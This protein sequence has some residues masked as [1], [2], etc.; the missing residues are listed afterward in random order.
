MDSQFLKAKAKSRESLLSQESSDRKKQSKRMPLVV[1]FHPALSGLDIKLLN[2]FGQ[3]Y[4]PR[5]TLRK[6]LLKDLGLLIG[7]HLI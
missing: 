1:K 6:S 2:R 3:F 5:K 7:E 4:M